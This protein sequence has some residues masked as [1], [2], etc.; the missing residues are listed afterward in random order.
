MEEENVLETT[1]AAT[2]TVN[3][4]TYFAKIHI[5]KDWISES[6]KLLSQT[7]TCTY[8]LALAAASLLSTSL[9]SACFV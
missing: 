7:Y 1:A 2:T 4:T 8:S 5:E 6:L 9:L 3:P